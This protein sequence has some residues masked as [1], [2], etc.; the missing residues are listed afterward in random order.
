MIPHIPIYRFTV[1]TYSAIAPNFN[2]CHLLCNTDRTWRRP[3]RCDGSSSPMVAATPAAAGSAQCRPDRPESTADDYRLFIQFV[4]SIAGSLSKVTKPS[5][6]SKYP[7]AQIIELFALKCHLGWL[8]ILIGLNNSPYR[9]EKQVVNYSHFVISQ[10]GVTTVYSRWSAC[11]WPRSRSFSRST[12][13]GTDWTRS[14]AR[15][16]GTRLP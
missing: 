12:S 1:S 8:C 3:S 5:R 7:T 11:R 13:S 14:F 2:H 6:W 10:D 15:A 4:E 16:P 9:H